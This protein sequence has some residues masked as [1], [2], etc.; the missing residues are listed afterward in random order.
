L[1]LSAGPYSMGRSTG[2]VFIINK[3]IRN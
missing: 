1:I 2:P 3:K